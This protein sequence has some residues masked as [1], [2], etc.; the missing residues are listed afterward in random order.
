MK[1]LLCLVM[2]VKDEAHGIRQ[3]LESVKPWIDRW[4]ILD[5]GST[6]GTQAIVREVLSDVTGSLYEEPF[7]DFGTTRSRALELAEKR[8]PDCVFSFMLSGDE[9]L[10]HGD[11]LRMFCETQVERAEPEHEVYLI[12]VNHADGFMRSWR[13]I[14]QH[15]G[16][17][18]EGATHEW[19][20]KPGARPPS[21]AVNGPLIHHDTSHL[22][23]EVRRVRWERD[24]LL[25]LAETAKHPTETRWVYYLAQTLSCLGELE[26]ASHFYRKRITMGGWY[27]ELFFAAYR[28]AQISMV[29]KRPWIY[30]QQCL[31]EAH[32]HCPH[33]AEPL[34]DIACHFMEEKNYPVAYLFARRACEVSFPTRDVLP[35]DVEL[36]RFLRWDLLGAAALRFGDFDLGEVGIRKALEARPNEERLLESLRFYEE[37]KK[38]AA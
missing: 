11:S 38:K 3:T 15:R 25:L 6:D 2:I 1:P 29:Q 28:I 31:L 5:T 22:E 7:V 10:R 16:W 14:R 24:K 34:Y 19:L 13:L 20:N 30:T 8:F 32:G 36:Y 26:L 35:F 18:Y 33:R 17:R 4:L 12:G 37:R 23:P 21:L 9:T 27:E